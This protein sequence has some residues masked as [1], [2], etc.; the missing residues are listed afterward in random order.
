MKFEG[1]LAM[2]TPRN[3]GHKTV[4]MLCLGL[5]VASITACG[6]NKN[7]T[8]SNTLSNGNYDNSGVHTSTQYNSP[9]FSSAHAAQIGQAKSQLGCQ[10]GSRLGQDV[11]FN[12]TTNASASR[13]GGQMN[14]GYLSGTVSDL[15][16]GV[17]AFNDLMFVSKVV[18]GSSVVGYN[19]T[20]SMCSYQNLYMTDRPIT[21][22]AAP[23]G[24]TL[25]ADSNCGFGRAIATNTFV[26]SAAFTY[27]TNGYQVQLP[28][29][30]N[31]PTTFF[32]INCR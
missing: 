3:K 5:L 23:N 27:T 20:L 17:S 31:V 32:Q 25:S 22:F 14:A 29:V 13:I 18:N 2:Y 4:V 12:V 6:D 30:S 11:T 21:G 24:I 9:S 16:I 7:K 15:Y 8:N 26:Q 10:G 28:A 1:E 19:V